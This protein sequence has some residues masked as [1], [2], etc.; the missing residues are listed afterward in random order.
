ML[1]RAKFMTSMWNHTVP[2]D[3]YEWNGNIYFRSPSERPYLDNNVYVVY[4]K[5]DNKN[6]TGS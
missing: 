1:S 2:F 3:P 5:F 6:L 4:P